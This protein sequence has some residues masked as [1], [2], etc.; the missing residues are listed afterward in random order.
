MKQLQW[1]CKHLSHMSL[2]NR[3]V[4][5]AN[6]GTVAQMQRANGDLQSLFSGLGTGSSGA[7]PTPA[8][9]AAALGADE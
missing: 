2:P 8:P 5:R 1:Q 9:R 6:H 4:I 7:L 3:P